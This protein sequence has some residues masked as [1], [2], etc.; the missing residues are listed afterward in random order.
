M[1]NEQSGNG[2]GTPQPKPKA[3]LD[4]IIVVSNAKTNEPCAEVTD[5]HL[6]HLKSI[7]PTNPILM[8]F[9]NQGDVEYVKVPRISSVAFTEMLLRFQFHLTECAEA[10]AFDQNVLMKR[11]KD[12]QA[13]SSSM[14]KEVAERYKFVD[15]C[16]A[17]VEKISE[18]ENMVEKI[19]LNLRT[20]KEKFDALNQC[21]PE[22]ERIEV[23][24]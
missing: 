7:Q 15:G 9:S 21:L 12:V 4:D 16:I 1:G 14:S 6:E 11:I 2:G 19:D 10:V 8:N 5:Q 17:R 13:L 18:I 22:D 23:E 20:T 3:K 24:W